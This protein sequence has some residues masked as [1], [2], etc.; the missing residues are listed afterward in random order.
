MT[1]LIFMPGYSVIFLLYIKH[2]KSVPINVLMLCYDFFGRF[3]S[4]E[5]NQETGCGITMCNVV[6]HSLQR[7]VISF[8]FFIIQHV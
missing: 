3:G 8:L 4:R 7:S 6:F 1:S 2:G 5:E